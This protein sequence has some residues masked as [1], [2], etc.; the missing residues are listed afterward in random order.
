[1]LLAGVGFVL[2]ATNALDLVGFL[3]LPRRVGSPTWELGLVAQAYAALPLVTLGLALPLASGIARDDR[4]L[5]L[6][7]SSLLIPL[8]TLLLLAPLL[9]LSGLVMAWYHGADPVDRFSLK[10]GIVNRSVLRAA[11]YPLLHLWLGVKGLRW[12]HRDR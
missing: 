12:A 8:G 9:Y 10:Q 6:I 3:I 1:M 11:I 5:V 2:L 4:K 7:M